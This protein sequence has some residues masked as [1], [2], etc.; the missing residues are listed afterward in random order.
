MGPVTDLRDVR[1][2]IPRTR[3]AL[4]GP[5]A[6]GSGSVAAHLS[7][8]E[9][10]GLIADAIGDVIFYSGGT[11]FGHTL[12][13][14]ARD[15]YYQ[16]PIDW[17]TDTELTLPEQTIVI[18]QAAI[19]YFMHKLAELQYARETIQDEGQEWTY[20][21]P[22]ALLR[23]QLKTLT[24]ARDKALETVKTQG[25]ALDSYVSFITERDALVAAYIEPWVSGGSLPS[26]MEQGW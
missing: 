15:T 13:V 10:T 4:D 9:L 20:E 16:A 1:V 17:R 18:A 14:V 2:L 19:N 12:E 6:T 3:R 8:D 5:H 11:V 7:D 26:G 24:A 21:I 25:A 22:A 23:E